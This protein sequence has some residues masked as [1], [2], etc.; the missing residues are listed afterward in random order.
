MSELFQLDRS[1]AHKANEKLF[2][3]CSFSL[4]SH[5]I[6]IYTVPKLGDLGCEYVSVVASPKKRSSPTVAQKRSH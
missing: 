5:K 4:A 2:S 3:S 6:V 1:T